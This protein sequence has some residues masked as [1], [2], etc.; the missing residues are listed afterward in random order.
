MEERNFCARNSRGGAGKRCVRGSVTFGTRCIICH[1]IFIS[2]YVRQI[3]V[4]YMLKKTSSSL[5]F[6]PVYA[7][8][9]ILRKFNGSTRLKIRFES[10]FV[11]TQTYV[12]GQ[13]V[14]PVLERS[15]V[16]KIVSERG[17]MKFT[18]TSKDHIFIILADIYVYLQMDVI[19]QQLINIIENRTNK[20][21][22]GKSFCFAYING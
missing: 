4:L 6:L 3:G 12:F 7:F 20:I 18:C 13:K 22:T 15:F 21:L 14:F 19:F 11:I 9:N 16:H 1:L 2:S 17:N 5:F 8:D 10:R